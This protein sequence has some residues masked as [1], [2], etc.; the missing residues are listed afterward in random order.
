MVEKAALPPVISFLCVLEGVSISLGSEVEPTSWL[1]ETV[2]WYVKEVGAPQM[3][4]CVEVSALKRV[5]VKDIHVRHERGRLTGPNP[6]WLPIRLAAVLQNPRTKAFE[7]GKNA[8]AVSVARNSSLEIIQW[9][10][11]RVG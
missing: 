6:E 5:V 1:E 2:L 8:A 4:D 3:G 11:A 10:A 9:M 7:F